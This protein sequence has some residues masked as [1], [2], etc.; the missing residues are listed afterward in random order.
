[1]EKKKETQSCKVGAERSKLSSLEPLL[2]KS[3]LLSR[4]I[5]V[6]DSS[7]VLQEMESTTL[8]PSSKEILVSPWV[9]LDQMSQRMQ[10]I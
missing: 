8:P 2:L 5:R 4:P 10:L 3:F 1:M 6:L 9:F 7:V